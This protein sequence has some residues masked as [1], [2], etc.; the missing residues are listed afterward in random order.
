[1]GS[2]L[3]MWASMKFLPERAVEIEPNPNLKSNYT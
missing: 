1:M 2:V 3:C